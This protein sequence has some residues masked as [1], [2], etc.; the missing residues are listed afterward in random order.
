MLPLPA[1]ASFPRRGTPRGGADTGRRPRALLVHTADEMHSV[2]RI[3]LAAAEAISTSC[4]LEVWLPE[5]WRGENGP[6]SRKLRDDGIA[7][8]YVPIPVLRNR[9]GD[10]PS[11]VAN[12]RSAGS[13]W[14]ALGTEPFDLVYLTSSN[15]ATVAPLARARS[16]ARV[17]LHVQ[18]LWKDG[19]RSA[20]RLLSAA[21]TRVL[22]ISQTVLTSTGMRKSRRVSLLPGATPDLGLPHEDSAAGRRLPRY[23][24]ASRWV[25][26]AGYPTL[27]RAWDEAGCPG[28]L[29]IVSGPATDIPAIDVPALVRSLVSRPN[30]V[31]I[32]GEIPDVAEILADADAVIVPAESREGLGLALIEAHSL[33][34]PGIASR[35]GGP[36]EIIHDGV[37]GWLFGRGNSDEL[38]TLLRNLTRADL[39]RAGVRAREL[40]EQQYTVEL[41]Q[42][43]L[44]AVISAELSGFSLGAA[45]KSPTS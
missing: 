31:S 22:A 8:R 4:V 10:R 9:R 15:A 39:A 29:V 17:I 25:E 13:T 30:T 12:L 37:T 34:R 38:A 19:E 42:R 21:C 36:E 40:Y 14:R 18:E 7:V 41:L 2:D 27:L 6:L 28:E 11:L 16:R 23:V 26:G 24:V 33:S 5:E 45:A 3:A 1:I 32:V 43:R 44:R 35:S 20:L